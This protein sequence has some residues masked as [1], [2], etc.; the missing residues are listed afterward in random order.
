M[1]ESMVSIISEINQTDRQVLHGITN[2]YNLKK[3]KIKLIEIK[4]R[5]MAA[6]DCRRGKNERKL[7]KEYKLSV[8]RLI[9]SESLICSMM[10]TDNDIV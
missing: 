5:I 6:M 9:K 10:I 1:G 4:S 8:I 3:K 7:I 2:M